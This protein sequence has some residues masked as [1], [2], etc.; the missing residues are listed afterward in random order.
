MNT[1]EKRKLSAE[2]KRIREIEKLEKL[3]QKPKHNG[4]FW[5]LLLLLCVIYICDEITTAIGGQMQSII[6]QDLFAPIFGEEVAVARMSALN[7]LTMG[8]T[9]LAFLYKP[10]SDR[11]GRRIF[12]ITNTIGMGI[13]LI[14]TS[15][16]TG[17]PVYLLGGFVMGFF[18]PHDM[19][20]VYIL[21]TAPAKKRGTYYSVMKAVA[22]LGIIF[23]PYLRDA[24]LG[25]DISR[26]RIVY[27]VFG[28]AAVIV[29]VI[30]AFFVQES[31]AFID[32]RLRQL[33]MSEEERAALTAKK[34]GS[35]SEGGLFA[36][37]RFCLKNKQ[38]RWVLFSGGFLMFG[39]LFSFYYESM[40]TRGYAAPL[41]AGGMSFAD[42]Q[43]QVLPTVTQA[44][45]FFPIG[46]AVAQL[47]PGLISDR[48]GRR[49]G[50]AI[51]C[52]IST[53]AYVL[54]FLGCN[55]CW[56]SWLVGLLSGAA[57]G[58]YWGA[59]DTGGILVSESVPTNLRSSVLTIQPMVSGFIF[60]F[61]M[62]GCTVA[63]NILG[64]SY[65]GLISLAIAVP[66]MLLGII[67]MMLKVKE[68]QG[69]DLGAV[70]GNEAN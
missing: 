40:M 53:A 38:C 45:F 46:S 64:D 16:A 17:L 39:M 2:E 30:S 24:I 25:N 9:A 26:W 57:I 55:G 34:D 18:T 66:G 56:P 52:G 62:M 5:Y 41:M 12:L 70:T 35:A 7:Y 48:I 22:T 27:Q 19:Q 37:L 65:A 33:R 67:L 21:E 28:F 10:L 68:T 58:S 13:G 50:A 32:N 59:G 54:F 11:F 36:G 47:F 23:V 3:R 51:M 15:M 60:S 43:A 6:A 31:D 29:A 4:Y 69:A 49:K 42:A 1:M 61:A 8:S 63:V 44:L 20:M 14:L